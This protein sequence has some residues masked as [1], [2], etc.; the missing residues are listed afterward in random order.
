VDRDVDVLTWLA[1][2]PDHELDQLAAALHAG[3][4]DVRAHHLPLAWAE[5]LDAA[6]AAGWEPPRLADAANVARLSRR[7]LPERDVHVVCTQPGVAE[8]GFVDTPV[9]LRRLFQHARQDVLLAGFRVTERALLEPLRRPE[10]KRLR[11]RLFVDLHPEVDA[12]GVKRAPA[13]PEIYPRIWWAQFLE[14]V[15]PEAMDPP[16]AW[17]SPLTLTKGEHGFVS[18]HVKAAVVDGR[19]WLVTSAN[20][21]ERGQ[22]RNFELGALVE[23][24]G[25]AGAVVRHFEGMVG[26]GVF[27]RFPDV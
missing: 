23:D 1:G 14:H 15:W 20:F 5:P 10:A 7:A 26:A 2:L 9:V 22:F 25:V 6:W 12:L 24:A 13:D 17:Y 21:T 16:E 3:R 19:K 27:V 11:I 8:P 4:V 18:M